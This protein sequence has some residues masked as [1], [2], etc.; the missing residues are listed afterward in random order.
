M[1]RLVFLASL[2][3]LLVS[4]SKERVAGSGPVTST[5][6]TLDDAFN[7]VS[8]NGSMPV[9]IEKGA[10]PK[11]VVK[12]YSNLF[13]HIKTEVRNDGTLEI[14]IAD[15]VNIRNNNIE[16]FVTLPYLNKVKQNG[17]GKATVRSGFK[18]D[19]MEADLTGSGSITIEGGQVNSFSAN[20]SGSG[21]VR[22]FGLE[23]GES[24]VWLSGSGVVQVTTYVKLRANVSGSGE[25]QYK[26]NPGTVES[27]VSG[28]G[29][30][31]RKD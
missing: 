16:V 13:P 14:G 18:Q 22:A 1:Y 20:L 2:L 19:G 5:E 21:K 17:S 12:G 29:I 8:A 28:S 4:C 9:F 26:G 15:E 3:L 11:V 31:V 7:K 10:T 23:T 24:H 25:V 30:V 27:F 6:R